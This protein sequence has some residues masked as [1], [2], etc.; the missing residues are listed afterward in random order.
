MLNGTIVPAG[1]SCPA[2]SDIAAASRAIELEYAWGLAGRLVP[3]GSTC[4]PADEAHPRPGASEPSLA[5][6]FLS[7]HRMPAHSRQATVVY[8]A[9]VHTILLTVVLL[10]P[11]WFTD[12][13]DPARFLST[14][15]VAPPQ[16]MTAP[17]KHAAVISEGALESE[18][19]IPGAAFGGVYGGLPGGLGAEL[20]GKAAEPPAPPPAVPAE[21]VIDEPR[22]PLQVGGNV[23]PP[24]LVHQVDPIYPRLAKQARVQGDVVLSAIINEQGEVTELK[25]VTGPPLLFNAALN[26]VQQW[27]FQPTYLNGH[28]WPVAHE[29][30]VH[31]R[32]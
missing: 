12:A 14:M 18:V 25:V 15:L 24:K 11:L 6:A 30:T 1:S 5:K 26:A 4:L 21:P 13:M 19:G 27:K 16:M 23:Q 2:V 7:S 3:A 8:S 28:P 29:I 31:F 20:F 32:L 17:P 10:L 22:K 9:F